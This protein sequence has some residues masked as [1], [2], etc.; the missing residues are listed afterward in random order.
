MSGITLAQAQERLDGWLAADAAV[1]SN[2]SYSIND[3]TLTRANAAEIRRNI[4]YW[5]DKV[6]KLSARSGGRGGVRYAVPN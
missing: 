3:R 5:S 6:E 1:S 2:Q 4:D